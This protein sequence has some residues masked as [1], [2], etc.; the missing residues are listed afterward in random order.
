MQGLLLIYAVA[1]VIAA[2]LSERI[3][4]SMLSASVL[5]LAA[6]MLATLPVFGRV[7]IDPRGPLVS[8]VAEAALFAVLFTD[9]MKIGFRE[10]AQAARLPGRALLFGM[11]LTI[12]GTALLAH[13]R[14]SAVDGITVARGDPQ[15]DRP[16]AGVGDHRGKPGTDG[17]Y[18]RQE[19]IS[20]HPARRCTR[21]L[22][23]LG[24]AISPPV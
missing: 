2:L 24:A 22:A 20:C 17:T 4:R 10:I 19:A 12:A 8:S 16:R 7:E 14:W 3:R 11:P 5:F 23:P 1:L 15:P 13:S 9:G 21:R 6:G 18:S